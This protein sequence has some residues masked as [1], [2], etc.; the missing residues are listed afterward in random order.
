MIALTDMVDDP[1][2]KYNIGW[3]VAIV[4]AIV[5][6]FNFGITF[7]H[8]LDV[9]RRAIKKVWQRCRNKK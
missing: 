9:I 5:I 2:M 1:Y 8:L 7:I 4:T 3:S 6:V